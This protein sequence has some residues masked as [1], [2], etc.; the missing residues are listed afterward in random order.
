MEG[1]TIKD[2]QKAVETLKNNKATPKMMLMNP[3]MKE[4]VIQMLN[5]QGIETKGEDGND[6]VFGMKVIIDDW[7]DKE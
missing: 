2:I 3:V 4:K 7:C 5:E 6:Y 1:L